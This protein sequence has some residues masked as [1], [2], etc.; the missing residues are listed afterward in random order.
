[1]PDFAW[2]NITELDKLVGFQG[3]MSSF[4]LYKQGW[5]LWYVSKEPEN[6]PVVGMSVF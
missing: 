2:D 6:L 5:Q 3:V 4:V 1:L